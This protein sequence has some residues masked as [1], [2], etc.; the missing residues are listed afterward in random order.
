MSSNLVK[1][2][3]WTED[4]VSK[5]DEETKYA[6]GPSK[7]MSLE[8]GDN[9]VR[10]LPCPLDWP[11]PIVTTSVHYINTPDGGVLSF[12]CIRTASRGEQRCPG[13][14][15]AAK[16]EQSR[17]SGMRQRGKRLKAKVQH[18]CNVIDRDNE[19]DGPKILRFG[20][21]IAKKLKA[22]RK[23]KPPNGGDFMDPSAN[24]FDIIITREGEGRDTRYEATPSRANSAL[25]DDSW[26]DQQHLL[27]EC[28]EPPTLKEAMDILQGKKPDRDAR[29]QRRSAAG[30]KSS[31]YESR[32]EPVTDDDFIDVDYKSSTEP[33]AAATGA[34]DNWDDDI[35]F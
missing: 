19:N 1:Y 18:Y 26:L 29:E 24:G 31:T 14:E 28:I 7:Y 12:A 17:D 22:I 3:G 33:A 9:T 23:R 11:A 27:D 2:R 32:A 13:C 4:D 15:Q 34:A 21:M 25:G 20:P 10:F 30:S 8:E 5:L 16:L 6:Q 35:P